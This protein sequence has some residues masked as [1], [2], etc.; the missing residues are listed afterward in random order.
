[1]KSTTRL[2]R[3]GDQVA[4]DLEVRNYQ[5]LCGSSL[6]CP[7]L[8]CLLVLPSDESQ[9]LSVTSKQLAIRGSMYWVS[10]TGCEP[11]TNQRSCRVRLP[12]RNL[13]SPE[14]LHDLVRQ[15]NPRGP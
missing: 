5:W 2:I 9:W 12:R 15:N 3:D 10:L 13:F 11:T 7:R 4:Y 14:S 6:F 8:L 1:M